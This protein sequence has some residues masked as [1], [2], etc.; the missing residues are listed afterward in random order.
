[1]KILH[2]MFLWFFTLFRRKGRIMQKTSFK[3]V[4]YLMGRCPG[5]GCPGKEEGKGCPDRQ[6][7]LFEEGQQV[8]FLFCRVFPHKVVGL[9]LS[10]FFVSCSLFLSSDE[11]ISE[12]G[13]E[14]N[15]HFI[16]DQVEGRVVTTSVNGLPEEIQIFYKACF[17][18]FIHPDNTLQ[19]SVFKIHL[20]E[21]SGKEC[22][23]SSS[24]LFT[25]DSKKSCL[26]IRTDSSGCL[27]WTEVYPYYPVDQSVWFGYSRAFE[28]TGV[29]PGVITI[30]MAVNPWLALD[31]SGSAIQLQLVDLRYHPVD[32]KWTLIKLKDKDILE[33]RSCSVSTEEN[34]EDKNDKNKKDCEICQRKNKS[35]S[36]VI[37]YFEKQVSRPRLWIDELDSN[38]S[39]EHIF[40][41]QDKQIVDKDHIQ[42]LRQFNVCH[43]DVQENCDPPGRFFKVRLRMPLH[44]KVRNYRNEEELL[45]LTRGHYSVQAYLFLRDDK[46]KNIALHRDMSFISTPLSKGSKGTSLTSEFYLHVPY[47]HYGLPAFLGLKVQ[48]EGELKSFF[49]PFESVFSFPN[50]L[51]SVIGKNTLSLNREVLSFYE[52]PSH[53]NRS[54]IKSYQLTG[55]WLNRQTEGFRRAGW[56]VRL[57]RFRFSGIGVEKNRCPS[58]VDRTIR[59]VGEVCIIDPLTNEVVPNTN[60]TIQRQD[61]FFTKDGRSWEGEVANIPEIQKGDID[62]RQFREGNL[63]DLNNKPVKNYKYIS[64]TSGCL[65]WVDHL[66]HKWYDREKYFVRKMIFSKRE[67]GFEGERMIAINPW[68][69]G[70][71]FFQD[72]TQLGHSS[73]RTDEGGAERP[74]IVL[75]DFR[76]LFPDPVYT[77]DRWLGIN[78]F[79]NLLFLFRVRVDR[80]DNISVG[81]GG[82]R[83]SAQDV[84]RGYYFLRFIL[85]KSH[86]EEM[87]GKGN[88]VVN[89]EEYRKQYGKIQPWNTNTGWKVGRNGKQI[90]QMMSTNLEYITHFDTYVQIRDSVVNAYTNFLFDL[91]E[92]IFIGSN[93]RLIVQLLPTDPKYYS[94]YPDSCEIDPLKSSFV[95]F[96]NHELITRPFMGTFVPGDQ[97]NW[98]IFRVLSEHVNLDIN[99]PSASAGKDINDL[100]VLNMSPRQMEQFIRKGK[101]SSVE[102][103]LFTKLQSHFT[104]ET[105]NWSKESRDLIRNIGPVFERLYEDI[106]T[107]LRIEPDKSL[108]S[109]FNHKKNKLI[110]SIDRVS[111]VVS[112]T[113]EGSLD[114]PEQ[115]FFRKTQVLL[116]SAL[117]FLNNSTLSPTKFK[118]E[119]EKLRDSFIHLASTILPGTVSSAQIGPSLKETRTTNRWFKPDIPFPESRHDWSKF[120]MNLFAKDEGL[121]VITMDDE[122]AISQFLDDLNSYAT[123]HNTYYDKYQ[124]YRQEI[125]EK[126]K[127]GQTAPSPIF[128][129]DIDVETAQ[130][131]DSEGYGWGQ[132][133][134]VAREYENERDFLFNNFELLKGDDFYTVRKKISQMYLPDFSLSWLDKVLVN[135]VHSG[136]LLTPEVMTFAH[137]LCGFWFD[138]FYEKYL[139]REQLNTIY[140]KHLD[141]FQYY[142]GTLEYLLKSTGT[143]EQYRS[144]YQ[145]MQ[146]YNLLPMEEGYFDQ[147]DLLNQSP[148]KVYQDQEDPSWWEM[149]FASEE[150]PEEISEET[151]RETL[152]ESPS[153][154]EDASI[155]QSLYSSLQ[156][157]LKN[158]R[159]WNTIS[160]ATFMAP[161]AHVFDQ[162][163]TTHRHPFFKCVADPFS[164]FHIEKKI[165]VGDIGSD[166]SDLKYEYGLTKSYNVQRAFD[167]AYS[168]QW[169]M[170]RS[171]SSSI[172]SGF[173][174]LELSGG[175]G[176]V[177]R[178]LNPLKAVTPF[179][180]FAGV[181][182][183]SDWSTSRSD[184]DA[185]RRQQSLRFADES[186]YLQVNH[187]SISIRLKNFRHCLVVRAKNQAFDGY[188]KDIV[189]RKD[190]AENFIHRIPYIKS[191]LMICSQDIDTERSKEPFYITEDYFYMYQLIPGDRGQF[192]NPL[193]FRNR[194]YVMS[195]RGITEMEKLGLLLHSFVEADK[196]D[197]MEDYDP[198]SLMTN[199]YNTASQPA[200]GTRQMIQKAKIWDKTGF[201]PGV[202]SVKYDEEHYFFNISE[203]RKKGMFEQFGEF[204]YK[205][206]PL[207]YIRIDDTEPVLNRGGTP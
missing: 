116:R 84:R 3:G 108:L 152:S 2:N 72:I 89:D 142:K 144:L 107:L 56:D 106:N 28:G 114:G 149:L 120:N 10:F 91:D 101:E 1:M 48:A 175:V 68:H 63:M 37:S 206:N 102:H 160:V 100:M 128:N 203:R 158:A 76:S 193:S 118:R 112:R 17:R 172:G 79:Q 18:D 93:N 65:Q 9:I 81:Q 135:G 195:V 7:K 73:I 110:E 97:R 153:L 94:Y 92:F 40:I 125:L 201:Y 29:N 80:P 180:S 74:Q 140:L 171:F 185:N 165:L 129:E 64:D 145:A 150:V 58:P 184:A 151:N 36:A 105:D 45:P 67:W 204:L 136:T 187:S 52:K 82:Q 162:V 96:T 168:S 44:I 202:Y 83:P 34:K 164:F 99:I 71:V 12:D 85:V 117:F 13:N 119:A 21:A 42:A 103:E 155:T 207:G 200:E 4:Y 183:S 31:P 197:G 95:P 62:I 70:F 59:Y 26:K 38:I 132:L 163:L 78:L 75:H 90:G 113:V 198:F 192:Q 134:Q 146:K 32:R 111:S 15:A 60:I 188:E 104:I 130:E 143:M 88:Q 167:Y 186:L 25:A 170:S 174:A 131:E 24:F 133:K 6:K 16:L 87:G 20:F 5:P 190:L 54:L 138:K 157:I 147:D 14:N 11:Q 35:L 30:P 178:F 8:W 121:K 61:V 156:Y 189:W 181:K 39:Q 53:K 176:A 199:P 77:I 47:E 50:R 191:G 57:N 179:L 205:N 139:Q 196:N 49:L 166:Y 43:S 154:P 182:L 124:K 122:E 127:A 159:E 173:G 27:N 137:S 22:S 109:E 123:I 86:T 177:E 126:K 55:S 23:E 51:R 148:F 41:H 98:N 46:G 115:T 161:S 141:H 169:S 66:Y 194:P 69:W 33:C 19:N